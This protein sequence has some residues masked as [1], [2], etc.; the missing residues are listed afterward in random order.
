LGSG[1]LKHRNTAIKLPQ[2]NVVG[3]NQLLGAFPCFL[4]VGAVEIGLGAIEAGSDGAE[5]SSGGRRFCV[6]LGEK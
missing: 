3:V 2:L 6:D 4:L 1:R 5:W